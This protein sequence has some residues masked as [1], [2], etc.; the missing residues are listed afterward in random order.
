MA[1]GD[2]TV[3]VH[4]LRLPVALWGR[5]REH[6]D[7]M[8]REFALMSMSASGAS[9]GDE[10]TV[11]VR[12]VELSRTLRSQYATATSAQEQQLEA[13]LE[14][15]T[16]ELDD[17]VYVLPPAAADASRQLA[18]LYDEAD[19]HCRQGEHL[20]TL[21]TPDDLVA[22]RRWFLGEMAEQLG[23]RAPTPWPEY[24]ARA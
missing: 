18:A 24:A 23:G 21:S 6:S 17:L 16:D 5:A 15:G 13:A 14:A 12:L 4:L 8:Q 9:D 20:L 2:Q 19:E 10:R 3:E 7:E 11:P 22:F 1:D